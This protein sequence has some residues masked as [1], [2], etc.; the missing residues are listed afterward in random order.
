MTIALKTILQ[1]PNKKFKFQFP[2]PQE[3]IKSKNSE[4]FNVLLL[5][6]SLT[7]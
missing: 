6:E 7:V 2:T 4:R 3:D 5:K 1:C